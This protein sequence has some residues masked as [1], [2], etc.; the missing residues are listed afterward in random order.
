L[1]VLIL[2]VTERYSFKFPAVSLLNS[3]NSGKQTHTLPTVS[4][5]WRAGCCDGTYT[6]CQTMLRWCHTI[7][8][9]R[10]DWVHSIFVVMSLRSLSSSDQ[11]IIHR[12]VCRRIAG[13]WPNDTGPKRW[14]AFC[15][16]VEYI[17]EAFLSFSEMTWRWIK[18]S[19]SGFPNI[20]ERIVERILGAWH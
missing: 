8:W 16:G 15:T 6:T 19:W 18:C 3:A 1:L 13:T 10:W 11:A 7:W 4:C 17:V 14:K 2:G 5:F 9:P 20:V 12:I